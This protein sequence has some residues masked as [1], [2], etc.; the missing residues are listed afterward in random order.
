MPQP[1]VGTPVQILPASSG[2][3][4]V[5][6]TKAV[7]TAGI[8]DPVLAQAVALG[9]QPGQ[10]T[11]GPRLWLRDRGITPVSDTP[12]PVAST[13]TRTVNQPSS[14][15]SAAVVTSSGPVSVHHADRQA[16]STPTLHPQRGS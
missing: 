2:A 16:V 4:S 12:T 11:E 9:Y 1:S 3:A 10:E 15:T 8:T 6:G 14:P 13:S 5:G 7:S